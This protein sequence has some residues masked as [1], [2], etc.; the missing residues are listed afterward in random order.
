ML[1][2]MSWVADGTLGH[3]VPNRSGPCTLDCSNDQVTRLGWGQRG[4]G[5]GFEEQSVQ[6]RIGLPLDV[7]LGVQVLGT[8]DIAKTGSLGR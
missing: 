8:D 5:H 1:Q 7:Q 6:V 3:K 2:P 4:F